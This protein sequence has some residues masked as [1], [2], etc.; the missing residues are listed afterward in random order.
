MRVCNTCGQE[1]PVSEYWPDNKSGY[2]YK[3][4]KACSNAVKR[5]EGV[6]PCV[7]CKRILPVV[8]FADGKKRRRHVCDSCLW[9]ETKRCTRC[10][11][12]RPNADFYIQSNGHFYSYCKF[13]APGVNK[14]RNLRQEY[15]LWPEDYELML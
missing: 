13:C 1:K 6:K 15:Q 4:C 2:P 8:E 11:E 12:V 9:G 10:G 7:R 3:R 14:E 5:G